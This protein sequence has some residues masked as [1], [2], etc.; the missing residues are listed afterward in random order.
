MGRLF[1][2]ANVRFFTTCRTSAEGR[3]ALQCAISSLDPLLM[4]VSGKMRSIGKG[5]RPTEGD[6]RYMPDRL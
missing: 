5:H 4:P 6:G 3:G 1:L 2:D